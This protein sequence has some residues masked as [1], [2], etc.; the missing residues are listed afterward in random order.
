MLL[1]EACQ[2]DEVFDAELLGALG[3][4]LHEGIAFT[5]HD[6]A[7]SDDSHLS[8][9]SYLYSS[10]LGA[11][12]S[13]LIVKGGTNLYWSMGE[14]LLVSDRISSGHDAKQ[15]WLILVTSTGH[16]VDQYWFTQ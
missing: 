13:I 9:L 3:E 8:P 5:R 6:K 2:R 4:G 11:A 16:F 10:R 7:G 1:E 14:P 15:Y 12:F